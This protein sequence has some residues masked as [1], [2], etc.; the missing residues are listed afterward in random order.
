MS[1]LHFIVHSQSIYGIIFEIILQ[2]SNID[3]QKEISIFF[4]FWSLWFWFFAFAFRRWLAILS[5]GAR[6]SLLSFMNFMSFMKLFGR[7]H[8][9]LSMLRLYFLM[10]LMHEWMGIHTFLLVHHLADASGLRLFTFLLAMILFIGLRSF[11]WFIALIGI[12]AFV[13]FVISLTVLLGLFGLIAFF[14]QINFL[15]FGPFVNWKCLPMVLFAIK[16]FNR[17]LRW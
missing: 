12:Y 8:Y 11:I 9:D 14:L 4:L 1:I 6:L 17:I 15:V 16:L 13:I 3:L 5:G 7:Y 10:L 2:F